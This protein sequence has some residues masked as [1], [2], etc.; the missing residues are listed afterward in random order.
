MIRFLDGPAE[1]KALLLR[2]APFLLRAVHNK[3]TDTWDALDQLADAPRRGETAYVYVRVEA[4]EDVG[5]MH[6]NA[7]SRMTGR[8][9]G[10]WTKCA[11]YRL[12]H[13]QPDDST[14]RDT[15]SWQA[16]AKARYDAATRSL[17]PSTPEATDGKAQDVRT[18]GDA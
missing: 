18:P 3:R 13:E 12:Y 6:I 9:T 11:T 4:L 1:G 2:R 5:S 14:L 10:G 17:F 8:H 7:R 16:W 15:V